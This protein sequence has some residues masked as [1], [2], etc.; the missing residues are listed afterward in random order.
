MEIKEH[1]SIPKNPRKREDLQK[2]LEDNIRNMEFVSKDE[3]SV[4]KY[5]DGKYYR[6]DDNG[7]LLAKIRLSSIP[8][9]FKRWEMNA[10]VWG[11]AP[12]SEVAIHPQ[13]GR[14]I[15]LKPSN[16]TFALWGD[17]IERERAQSNQ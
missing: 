2:H 1:I 9:P 5:L 6:F 3:G 4:W 10:A 13:T 17:R 7:N 11:Y 15:R 14:E 16:A 12:P 8:D